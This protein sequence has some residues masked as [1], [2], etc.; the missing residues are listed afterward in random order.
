[1]VESGG[2]A[3][4]K[5]VLWQRKIQIMPSFILRARRVKEISINKLTNKDYSQSAQL[6]YEIEFK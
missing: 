3:K 5:C 1:M 6:Q 4:D 2:K